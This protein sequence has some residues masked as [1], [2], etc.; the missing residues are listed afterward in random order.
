M[1]RMRQKEPGADMV[2]RSPARSMSGGLREGKADVDAVRCGQV[3]PLRMD[4]GVRE[5]RKTPGVAQV[6]DHRPRRAR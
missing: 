4:D 6:M 1:W 3:P 2:L 5:L